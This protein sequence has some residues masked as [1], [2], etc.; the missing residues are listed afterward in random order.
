MLQWKWEKDDYLTPL[1]QY[2]AWNVISSKSGDSDLSLSLVLTL[3]WLADPQYSHADYSI[4][5]SGTE[6]MPALLQSMIHQGT[7][8]TFNILWHAV[9]EE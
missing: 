5:S 1:A 4:E 7:L 6:H 9:R 3:Q 2:A 8:S